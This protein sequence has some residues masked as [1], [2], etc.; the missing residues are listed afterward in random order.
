MIN[1]IIRSSIS[2]AILYLF[3]VAFLDNEKMHKF[4]RFYLLASLIFSFVVPLLTIPVL[5]PSVSIINVLDVTSFQDSNIQSQTT[6]L[7]KGSQFNIGWLI[8]AFYFLV[9]SIL[10]IRFLFNLIRLEISKSRQ[11]SII[12][13]GYKIVLIDELVLPYSFLSTIYVNSVEYKEG[14]IP[15]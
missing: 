12:Y 11:P 1:Y 9:S 6:T 14:R 5:T 10:L 15:K 13:E 3:F 7:H 4:N 2:L 8:M